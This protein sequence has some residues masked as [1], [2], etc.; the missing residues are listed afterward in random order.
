MELDML[1]VLQFQVYE[2]TPYRFLERYRKLSTTTAN[3]D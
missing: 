1:Q 3:D 2:P